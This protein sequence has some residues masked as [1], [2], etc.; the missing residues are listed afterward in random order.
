MNNDRWWERFWKYKPKNNNQHDWFGLW[1]DIKL[2]GNRKS[3]FHTQGIE[4]T[5]PKNLIE[6]E[7]YEKES[8]QR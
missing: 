1:A 4:M 3:V 7:N 5:H 2:S 6:E 8:V